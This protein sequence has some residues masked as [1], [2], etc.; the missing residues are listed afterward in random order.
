LTKIINVLTEGLTEGSGA[1]GYGMYIRVGL[2][3]ALGTQKLLIVSIAPH[4]EYDV[5]DTARSIYSLNMLGLHMSVDTM[6]KEFET[7]THFKTYAGER[8]P[9]FSANCNALLALVHQKDV[10]SYSTQIHKATKFL[11]NH[12]WD[13]DRAVKDKW[14]S[15]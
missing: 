5:D 9:S 13:A 6:V 8:D 10:L 1:I 4:F 12:W 11:C 15:D 2:L 3:T 14:A 7:S